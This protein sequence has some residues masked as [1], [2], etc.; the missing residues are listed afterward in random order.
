MSSRGGRTTSIVLP[1]VFPVLGKE[2]DRKERTIDESMAVP[3]DI[4]N[5]EQ[6]VPDLCDECRLRGYG[7]GVAGAQGWGA[8]RAEVVM[9]P[10]FIAKK[11]LEDRCHTANSSWCWL[12]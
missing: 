4:S 6:L 2:M 11:K 5:F 10:V 3:R 7:I 12:N 1:S 9:L 8:N